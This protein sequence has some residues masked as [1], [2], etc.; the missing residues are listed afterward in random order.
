MRRQHTTPL[1][2]SPGQK[3][4]KLLLPITN[5]GGAVGF[6]EKDIQELIQ[7]HP[8]CL[9]IAEIDPIFI[10]PVPIC[11]ELSTLSPVSTNGT[12]LRL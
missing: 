7:S 11:T 3:T 12:D 6:S 8:E 1:L 9:P 5:L 10:E 2:L 4:A